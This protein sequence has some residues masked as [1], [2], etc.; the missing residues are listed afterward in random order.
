[1]T[2][3]GLFALALYLASQGCLN[4]KWRAAFVLGVACEIIWMREAWLMGRYDL[5]AYCVL[6]CVCAGC[7]YW[8]WGRK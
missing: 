7:H 2:T 1:M 3:L 4:R 6:Y 5:L 8:A